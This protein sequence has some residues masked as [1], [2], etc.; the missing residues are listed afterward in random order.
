[1]R[2]SQVA[3]QLYTIRDYTKTPPDIAASMKKVRG[4]GYQAVQV[5]GMG[6]IDEKDLVKILNGEG[7]VCC[8]THESGDTILNS[9]G[10]VV[11]RLRKLDCTYTAYPYPSGIDFSNPAA[12]HDLAKRLNNAGKVL[13]DAG[14]VLTYHNHNV[15]FRHVNGKAALDVIYDET[16]RRCLQGEIDTYWV[17]AGGGCPV[18]WCG[19]LK[20]RLPLLH[21]KDYGVN[22]QNQG[23]MTEIGSGNINWKNV[24]RAAERA[25]C[26]WFIV[27]Q[28]SNWINSDPFEALKKSYDFIRDNLCG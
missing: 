12:V 24:I 7:L 19:R 13:A 22:A 21:I 6:P 9:P 17:Q 4:C 28:D 2:T 10:K 14:M 16:D 23:V 8:A 27:E 1:M 18:E 15:E 20:G 11:E 25:G 3:A 5:S 26:E